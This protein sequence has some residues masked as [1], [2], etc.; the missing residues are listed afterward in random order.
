MSPCKMLTPRGE[1][2]KVAALAEKQ[3]E[4]DDALFVPQSLFAD[5]SKKFKMQ[6]QHSKCIK[7]NYE[8]Y[9]FLK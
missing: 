4:I 5:D 7:C 9:R 1:K 2:K 8:I 6:N 3:N